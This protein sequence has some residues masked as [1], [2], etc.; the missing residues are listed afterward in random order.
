MMSEDI[1]KWSDGR[2]TLM[3]DEHTFFVFDNEKEER[4]TALKTT[5]RL[6]EQQATIQRM[7]HSL[8][9]IYKA[10]EKHYGYDMR[11]AVWLIDELNDEIVDELYIAET[12]SKN[13]K[14][15]SMYWK[16]KVDEQQATINELQT[17]INHIKCEENCE[18]YDYCCETV[19]S[20][21]N[22]IK[23]LKEENEQLK[24]A[25]DESDKFIA[26]KGLGAEFLNWC[27]KNE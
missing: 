3:F 11:N 10:F 6:N 17:I 9:T 24:K 4:M 22:E 5:K 7:K 18:D 15:A 20:L 16:K 13:R 2:Y 8:N 12:D 21:Y 14:E 26:K 23:H 19:C 27:V 1:H 25:R